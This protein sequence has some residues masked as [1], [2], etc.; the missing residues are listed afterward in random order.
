MFVSW[1]SIIKKSFFFIHWYQCGS[2]IYIVFLIVYISITAIN[3]SDHEI[4]PYLANGSPWELASMWRPTRFSEHALPSGT[5]CP[6]HIIYFSCSSPG[7]TI[8][9]RS[10]AFFFTEVLFSGEV[11]PDLESGVLIAS[12]MLMLPDT[13][14]RHIC[15]I[16]IHLYL[17]LCLC[18]LKAIN[19]QQYHQF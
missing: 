4:A 16:H 14:E 10:P 7:I 11:F 15:I 1:H 9:P 13:Q 3:Y 18:I 19:S 5:R 6:R 8:S 12:G 2:W 17:V